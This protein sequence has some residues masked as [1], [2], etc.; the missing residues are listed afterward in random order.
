MPVRRVFGLLVVDIMLD[1]EK[2]KKNKK[3]DMLVFRMLLFTPQKNTLEMPT[4]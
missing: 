1:E 3:K 2:R 4:S